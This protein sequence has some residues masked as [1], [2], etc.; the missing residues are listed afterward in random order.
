[1][2]VTAEVMESAPPA[3]GFGHRLVPPGDP[4]EGESFEA[5]FEAKIKPELVKCE[6]ERR[7]AM[8]SFFLALFAG[9]I[10][11]FLEFKMMDWWLHSAAAPPVPLL[12]FT[13][14]I[15]FGIGYWPLQKV[16]NEAKLGV[17]RSL[18][19]PIGVAFDLKRPDPP[20]FSE[21]LSLRL[22]PKPED[23]S[24][25]DFFSGRR[26]DVEFALC[27]ATLTQGSG[28]ERRTVFK[29]QL[30]RLTLPR[31]RL[32]T[33]VVLRNSGWFNRFECP[34]GLRAVGLEDPV[35]NKA[36]AVFG[37]DQVEAR[38]ILTPAFMQRMVDLESAYSGAHLRYGFTEADLLIAVE[39]KSRFEIGDMFSSLVKR[40]RVEGIARD[41][42]QVFKLIDQFAAT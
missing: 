13:A 6:A 41:L 25:E 37:S 40:A 28:K 15:A 10:V 9:V 18:C 29:G 30:F 23:Q 38:E 26:G 33:T 14:F 27:E 5:I 24:F 12:V 2:S 16:G 21:L 4:L 34:Q 1:M 17:I 20:F 36:F 19:E 39:G 11:I 32:S 22:L 7:G 42:E 35:F 3:G 31:K 8:K